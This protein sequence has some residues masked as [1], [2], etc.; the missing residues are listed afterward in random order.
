[1]H[2]YK[3]TSERNLERSTFT[4][5]MA[6]NQP[7]NGFLADRE[8]QIFHIL[9]RIYLQIFH[10]LIPLYIRKMEYVRKG[11]I[12]KLSP[13]CSNSKA[14]FSKS[15]SEF[16]TWRSGLGIFSPHALENCCYLPQPQ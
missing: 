14:A 7:L 16:H 2:D 5:G 4:G 8:L 3:K 12:L 13:V 11:G 9:R 1:M 10:I 6:R 15:N